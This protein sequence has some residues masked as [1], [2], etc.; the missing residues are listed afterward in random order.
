MIYTR[1]VDGSTG[2]VNR[3]LMGTVEGSMHVAWVQT[4]GRQRGGEEGRRYGRASLAEAWHCMASGRR[5]LCARGAAPPLSPHARVDHG[6]C[7][8]R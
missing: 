6:R 5:A 8:E 7:E 2:G 1:V 3:L 4:A